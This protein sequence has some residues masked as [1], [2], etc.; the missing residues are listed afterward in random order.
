MLQLRIRD[1]MDMSNFICCI[2]K[3]D[4]EMEALTAT[5][6]LG[7]DADAGFLFMAQDSNDFTA[8]ESTG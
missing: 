7:E 6:L 8:S 2:A 3:V 5:S 1:P 4:T